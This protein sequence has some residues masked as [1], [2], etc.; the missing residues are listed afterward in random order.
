MIHGEGTQRKL[1][2]EILK[3]LNTQYIFTNNRKYLEIYKIINYIFIYRNSNQEFTL[4][5]KNIEEAYKLPFSKYQII[6]SI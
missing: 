5:H 6:I 4:N 3:N 2:L 1:I